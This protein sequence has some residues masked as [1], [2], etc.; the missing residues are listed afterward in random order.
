MS[1]LPS[2]EALSAAARRARY[3]ICTR[4]DP[5]LH[6]AVD[7]AVQRPDALRFDDVRPRARDLRP[8]RIEKILQIDDLRFLRRARDHRPPLRLD[9]GEQDVLR[10]TDA[11]EVEFDLRPAQPLSL[12]ENK[13]VAL[14]DGDA[15]PLQ[16]IQVQIDGTQSDVAAA[17]IGDERPPEAGEQRTEHED[18]RAQLPR[19][20]GGKLVAAGVGAVDDGVSVAE[21]DARA[22]FL[23]DLRHTGDVGDMGRVADDD[24]LLRE[25]GCGKQGQHGIFCRL[26]PDAAAKPAAPVDNVFIHVLSYLLS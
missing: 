8:H 2:Q 20:D 17:R 1:A 13:A 3:E 9:G 25:N 15:Q 6:R 4:L 19:Q 7:D 11:R 24:P 12:A 10:R 22:K 26:Q 21:Y 5:V 14:G 16:G 23:E 18:G